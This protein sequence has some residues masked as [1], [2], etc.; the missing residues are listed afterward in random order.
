[1]LLEKIKEIC[2]NTRISKANYDYDTIDC[3]NCKHD[4]EDEYC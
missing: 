3:S 4:D 1:M 2:E